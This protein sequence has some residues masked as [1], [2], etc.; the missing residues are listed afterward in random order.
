[1]PR[2]IKSTGDRIRISDGWVIYRLGNPV[3]PVY[4]STR[5]TYQHKP[6]IVTEVPHIKLLTAWNYTCTRHSC[7][8]I[9]VQNM[10]L[11]FMFHSLR[12]ALGAPR[13][14]G[15]VCNN[16]GL[17]FLVELQDIIGFALFAPGG[18][19]GKMMNYRI[20]TFCARRQKWQN[21]RICTFCARW[22]KWQNDEL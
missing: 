4:S 16:I 15:Y 3:T 10:T 18:K 17:V 12:L 22:Q 21:Y 13:M 9:N 20:C 5:K 1:M 8:H 19:S 14:L 2:C 11:S 6:Y 7:V